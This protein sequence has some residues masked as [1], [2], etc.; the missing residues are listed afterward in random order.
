LARNCRI[1]PLFDR[2]EQPG[3]GKRF[4]KVA[5]ARIKGLPRM[6]GWQ[7]TDQDDLDAGPA[8]V[9]LSRNIK[10]VHRRAE[11]NVTQIA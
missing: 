4:L 8:A 10:A 7:T 6:T 9:R 11:I 3:A 1:H 2:L 5:V